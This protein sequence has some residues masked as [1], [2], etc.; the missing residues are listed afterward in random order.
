MPIYVPGKVVLAQTY[1]EGDR[2]FSNVSLLLHGDGT[3]GS[4]TIT[5]NSPSPKTVTAVGNAQI[6]TA[7]SKFGGA[8]IAFDGSGDGCTVSASSQTFNIS[9]NTYTI[10]A[11]VYPNVLSGVRVITD[12]SA[13]PAGTVGTIYIGTSGSSFIWGTRPS[14][15]GIAQDYSGGTLVV[16]TWTHVCLSI[17]GGTARAF[18]NGSQVGSNQTFASP[19]FTPFICGIGI[20]GAS[21]TLSLNG[22][23]D[24]IR[25]TTGV[26]RYTANFTPPTAAFV[27]AQY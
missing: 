17:N 27:D 22:Y 21:S 12:I 11:F 14:T 20:A 7:Q 2:N 15:G 16:N 19:T 18:V 5:D 3:N 24:E 4:T 23:L 13:I 1:V 6:S 9:Q 10:E 8:S 25:I 26:A